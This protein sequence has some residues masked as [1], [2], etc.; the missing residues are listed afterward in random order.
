MLP[1]IWPSDVLVIRRKDAALVQ[2]GELVLYLRQDRLFVHRLLQ[3]DLRPGLLLTKGDS[4]PL[5]DPP[6]QYE[7]YLGVVTEICHRGT[8]RAP[9]RKP[10]LLS[11]V[12]AG[13]F[14]KSTALQ[15]LALRLDAL[16]GGASSVASQAAPAMPC[17]PVAGR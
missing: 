9:S 10:W 16:R 15:S 1:Q 4:V 8:N 2:P 6:V 12:V 13:A 5:P 17:D 3:N 7:D 14:A 11:R